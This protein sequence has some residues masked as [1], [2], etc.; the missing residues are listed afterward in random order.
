[1]D[2]T[3]TEDD[4]EALKTAGEAWM[5]AWEAVLDEW[6]SE[7]DERS[8]TLQKPP[9]TA[10]VVTPVLPHRQLALFLIF[11]LPVT[12]WNYWWAQQDSNLRPADYE[13]DRDH[14]PL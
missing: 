4:L 2:R 11:V 1:M 12:H 6:R 10:S 13:S 5:G 8:K 7:L 14:T 3:A 9:E